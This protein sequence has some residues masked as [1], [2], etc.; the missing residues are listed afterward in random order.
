MNNKQKT[1]K[2]NGYNVGDKNNVC[3]YV[4]SS[5]SV[6]LFFVSYF[7]DY[8]TSYNQDQKKK[9]LNF[10]LPEIPLSKGCEESRRHSKIY[11]D[12]TDHTNFP[13][14]NS[15]MAKCPSD[16][17]VPLVGH[18][19]ERSNRQVEIFDT[20]LYNHLYRVIGKM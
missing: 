10:Y 2:L 7:T 5:V 6:I 11:Q 3:K 16:T 12:H 18:Q 8:V 13:R 1:K 20:L 14:V 17:E 15:C 4:I 9:I 19:V